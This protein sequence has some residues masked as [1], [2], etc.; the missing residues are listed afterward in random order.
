MIRPQRLF[1]SKCDLKYV[2]KNTSNKP[3][4]YDSNTSMFSSYSNYFEDEKIKSPVFPRK[5]CKSKSHILF[6]RNKNKNAS[7]V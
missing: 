7:I 2:P 1:Y 5:G 3:L 4:K 6:F